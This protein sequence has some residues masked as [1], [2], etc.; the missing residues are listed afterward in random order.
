MA[1]NYPNVTLVIRN[2]PDDEERIGRLRDHLAALAEG[3]D[4]RLLALQA[5]RLRLDQSRA[6]LET[7]KMLTNALTSIDQQQTDNR[8]R[9]LALGVDYLEELS[10]AYAGLGLSAE[11]ETLLYGMAQ[12]ATERIGD[13]I[14]DSTEIAQQ[15]RAVAIQ[16]KKLV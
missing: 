2:L 11:Q 6:I 8:K 4:A 14:G 9:L 10:R 5:E 7:T 12:R 13:A 1:V 16:F 15:L 3:A